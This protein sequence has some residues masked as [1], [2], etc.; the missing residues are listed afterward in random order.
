MLFPP[1]CTWDEIEDRVVKGLGQSS[2]FQTLAGLQEQV[3]LG[4]WSQF[5]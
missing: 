2:P 3:L 4:L 1:L 5:L